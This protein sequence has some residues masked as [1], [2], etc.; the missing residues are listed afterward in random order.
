LEEEN[1]KNE[2]NEKNEGWPVCELPPTE[3]PRRIG[4]LKAPPAT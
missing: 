2:K 4:R 3:S 1:E